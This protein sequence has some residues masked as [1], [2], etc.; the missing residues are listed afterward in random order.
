MVIRMIFRK[1]DLIM[2]VI[3][4]GIFISF[5]LWAPALHAA[6]I[7]LSK[8][9]KAW[10]AEHPTITLGFNPDMQPLLIQDSA[11]NHTGILPDIFHRLE[12]LTGL[13]IKIKL[14]PWDSI[15]IQAKQGDI[16]GLL[17]CIPA[18]AKSTGLSE[19]A[20]FISAMPVFFGKRDAP[21]QIND[22]NDI[23]GKRVA[24][25]RAV[26]FLED[27]IA[28]IKNDLTIIEV[29]SPL[30]AMAMVL[31]G[32]ADI[33]LGLNF[34]NYLLSQ[35]FLSGIEPV[36]IDTSHLVR[37]VTGIRAD[38][39]E[40]VS[41][42]DKG[43]SKIGDQMIVEVVRKWT[44]IEVTSARTLLT[45][46]EKA[47][48]KNH[49][50]VTFSVPT[51]AP[52]LYYL[53]N[54]GELAGI[55]IDYMRFLAKRIG[56]Q[57]DFKGHTTWNGALEDAKN[58]MVDGIPNA[59]ATDDRKPYLNFT[60]VYSIFPQVLVTKGDYSLIRRF[61][62]V[63]GKRIAVRK[64]S[65]RVYLLKDQ[66]PES[67]IVEVDHIEEGLDL[68]ATDRIDA[69]YADLAQVDA[70]LSNKFYT[71]LK[72][73]VVAETPPV[74]LARIG[75]RN[76]DPMLLHIFNKAI[77]SI[78][79]QE[80]LAIKKRWLP[81][82]EPVLERKIEL[83][84]KERAW[85]NEHPV[86][87]V[88]ADPNW[89]PIEFVGDDGSYQGFSIDLLNWVA[90]KLG[91]GFEF[92]HE[93]WQEL[94]NRAKQGQL[95]MFSCVAKTSVRDEYLLFT[96]IY[97]HMAAG[98]FAKEGVTYI[99]DLNLLIDRK[100]AV[101]EGYAIHD[102]LVD[103]FPDLKLL[104]V[105]NPQ[106]GIHA[107]LDGDAFVYVD[108]VI[109]TGHLISHKGYLQINMVGE[110]PFTF[111]QRMGVR[112]DWPMFRNI[113]QKAIDAISEAEL[114]AMYNQWV[115]LT[116]EKPMDYSLLW[117]IGG[118]CLIFIGLI[119]FWNRKL[120]T[121]VSN[122]TEELA[123]NEKRLKAIF[124]HRFQLTGLLSPD[125]KLLMANENVCNMVGVNFKDIEGKYL[126]ELPHWAHS[127][128]L[129]RQIQDSVEIASRGNLVNIETTHPHS[130]GTIHTIDFSLTPVHDENGEVIYIVPEGHDISE[131][132]K[133][134]I[135]KELMQKKLSQSQK[136]EAIGTLAGGIA[137]DFNNILSAIFGYS[138]IALSEVP[139]ESQLYSYLDKV[140]VAG[141]RAKK[142]VEQ[143][144]TFSR[145]QDRELKPLK[146]SLI[147]KEALQ[148]LRSS[149][150]TTIEIKSNIDPNCEPVL[151][152]PTQIQ[153]IVMNLCTNA[154]HAMKPKGGVLT[155]NLKAITR[156][157]ENNLSGSM[158]LEPG[159]YLELEV[160]DTGH[161]ISEENL[162][163]IFDPYFTT[164]EKGDGTGLGLSIVHGIIKDYGGN[165]EVKSSIGKGTRFL[166]YF[167]VIKDN[168]S[169]G[170]TK[171][172]LDSLPIGNEQILFVDD[173]KAVVD[174]SE[175]M[176]KS[177]GYNV[178]GFTDSLLAYEAFKN[179]PH[180]VDLMVTDMTM[181]K[182]T[183]EDLIR[184]TRKVRPDLPVILCTGYS[185][186]LNPEK[187]KK[188]GISEY[189]EKPVL[190][191]DLAAKIRKML[192]ER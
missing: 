39:P 96:D 126:W 184:Q 137:H 183:G 120:A 104:L 154:Y 148:L 157:Y 115:P 6:D 50:K 61:D 16:D 141:H 99:S 82:G 131:R 127:E 13:D 100:V 40:L 21:F 42:L 56:I 168:S 136:M 43:L 38:W 34:D 41:I 64:S 70:L 163:K 158:L 1:R 110:V 89:G 8:E 181:P 119:F 135:E 84:A 75:L 49:P 9:E 92:V 10:V 17:N 95:D 83:T 190:K 138:E 74:G 111:A 145:K 46:S 128:K 122:R 44:Q 185:D 30:D 162:E 91:V 191:K 45:S 171:K 102:Y 170:D 25:M 130:K 7:P 69:L 182:M 23:K 192:D 129:Q 67:K 121:E 62:D 28:P 149:I 26:K 15:I 159:H 78:S 113:L 19:T 176:L 12:D 172:E 81:I 123:S 18:L 88:G 36:F 2:C 179:A 106:E 151:A 60:D 175:I 27:L 86:I 140:L 59:D 188:M 180:D 112:K 101:V 11:G 132:K 55:N 161:G 177:L 97:I 142:L 20:G 139:R 178:K 124:N 134:E 109:T 48:L 169:S 103:K 47:W 93:N 153:Q 156:Q 118:G 187:V 5:L 133:A 144:L 166:V 94:I 76:D 165:V 24:H 14:G 146:I 57:I 3:Y 173:E 90:P 164:K 174:F 22:L 54:Q 4:T 105:N 116:Y 147:V 35:N 53:D 117:K 37:A 51:T 58:H 79:R 160:R 29:D 80:H 33:A 107:I 71:N 186:V 143:I 73:A 52:P 66:Y 114:Q 72:Y 87:R 85:L 167:P 98:L 65:S 125:G 155:I 31:E 152:D 32:K 77:A 108:N 189:L 68:L 150:P 63:S